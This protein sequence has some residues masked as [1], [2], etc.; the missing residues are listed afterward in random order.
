MRP[1]GEIRCALLA[2][3]G[4]LGQATTRQAAE[5]AQVGMR[6][7]TVT[8][9]HMVRA[10]DLVV[11]GDPIRVPGVRRPVPVYA[12]ADVGRQS[13]QGSAARGLEP[14]QQLV[15]WVLVRRRVR[16]AACT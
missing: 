4:Q 16:Q 8:V 3:F 10:G 7:A 15:S 13:A 11:Q 12:L 14:W 9:A 1:C 2:A 5:R 6:A